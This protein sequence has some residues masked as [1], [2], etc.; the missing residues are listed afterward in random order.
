[1]RKMIYF[2]ILIVLLIFIGCQKTPDEE[3]I[4]NK[5]DGRLEN[6]ITGPAAVLQTPVVNSISNDKIENTTHTE[7][8][9][10]TY[11]IPNLICNINAEIILPSTNNFP[12]YKVKQHKFDRDSVV[13]I[14]NYFTAN[15][16]GVRETSDTKEELEEQLIQVKRGA[17]IWDDNGGRWESYEGQKKDIADLEKRIANAEPEVFTSVNESAISVPM[18]KTYSI[19]DGERVYVD[20]TAKGVD[21]YPYKYGI[22]QP[23]SWIVKGD[24]YPGEPAGTTLDNVKISEEKAKN[25]AKGILT[26]LE[27]K[28]IGMA[29]MEKA[30]ILRDYTFETI[31]E[32]WQ[33]TLTRNDGGSIPVYIN[34]AE[35]YGTLYYPSEDYVERWQAENIKIYVDE[36]GIRAFSWK[37]SIEAENELNSNVP[38]LTLDEIKENVRE[39]IKYAFTKKT[40][41]KQASDRRITVNRMTLTNVLLPIKNESNYHMLAP[42]WI[43]YYQYKDSLGVH[44]AVIAV[45]AIDGSSIDLALRPAN[46]RR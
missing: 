16:T 36:N 5:G 12:V 10:E 35:I 23:E 20:T 9:R 22:I 27:I 2:L 14:I 37:N 13:K 30:R 18:N 43:V 40:D 3:V 28:N 38:L 1:M 24:A 39:Y 31:T 29:K 8:W 34:S 25:M 17:Y 6:I 41:G 45:N 4:I 7:T 46:Q 15:A 11:K 19:P 32:G 42:A 44:T 21:I 33:I 26:D